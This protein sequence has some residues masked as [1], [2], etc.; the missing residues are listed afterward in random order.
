MTVVSHHVHLVVLLVFCL[1]LCCA[2]L[3]TVKHTY[4]APLPLFPPSG[5]PPPA[6]QVLRTHFHDFMLDVH[7]RL[8]GAAGEA[9]PLKRVADELAAGHKVKGGGGERAEGGKTGGGQGG[10][11]GLPLKRHD[12]ALHVWPLQP[13][14]PPSE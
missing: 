11:R 6:A 4:P 7:S 12:H 9:D 1:L 13:L 5:R 3:S 10:R 8:R 2:S 14:F